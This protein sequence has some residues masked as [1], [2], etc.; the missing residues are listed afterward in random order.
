LNTDISSVLLT[1]QLSACKVQLR[2][3]K[4]NKKILFSEVSAL[5]TRIKECEEESE[6]KVKA[7][8]IEVQDL[9]SDLAERD[10][11]LM[12]WKASSLEL[13]TRVFELEEANKQLRETAQSQ[14]AMKI[15]KQKKSSRS[16]IQE[17]EQE[18]DDESQII[19]VAK[20]PVGSAI[21]SATKK[22]Q[23]DMGIVYSISKLNE[24]LALIAR[25]DVLSIVRFSTQWGDLCKDVKPK[26]ENMAQQLKRRN[27]VFVVVDHD[28]LPE[29]ESIC[30]KERVLAMP[31]VILYNGGRQLFRL[32]GFD[33]A[34]LRKKFNAYS[35]QLQASSSIMKSAKFSKSLW[36]G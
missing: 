11:E 4:K 31:T 6:L 12:D 5:R 8:Q 20:Q 24:F 32:D 16:A 23:Y 36:K 22:R 18:T 21:S 9:Q 28:T 30:V 26:F 29:G 35:S 25:Q 15:V 19:P 14:A 3:E 1:A 7:L 13:E 2:Q 34:I 17:P 10:K 33:E 27:A